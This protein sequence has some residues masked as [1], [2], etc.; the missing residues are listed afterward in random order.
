[1]A[2]NV[3]ID[4]GLGLKANRKR[5]ATSETN[6]V[7]TIRT[8]L[9]GG[10][11]SPISSDNPLQVNDSLTQQQ[12]LQTMILLADEILLSVNKVNAYLEIVT[13]TVFTDGDVGD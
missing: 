9:S 10:D 11:G 2:D 1:M 5:F 6:S 4:T 12:L 8:A 3:S 13:D 7:H